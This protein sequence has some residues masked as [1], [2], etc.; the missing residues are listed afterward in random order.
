[1]NDLYLLGKR[2]FLKENA[3]ITSQYE[4]CVACTAGA[5]AKH[6]TLLK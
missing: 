5:M 6:I 4:F 1:M 3:K 2:V